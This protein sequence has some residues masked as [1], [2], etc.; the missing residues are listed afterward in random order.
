MGT[1]GA[2]REG[3]KSLGLSEQELA[4]RLGISIAA[5]GDLE[6]YDDELA[7][8]VSLGVNADLK[9]THLWAESPK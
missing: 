9:V 6:T 1:G 5:H 2:I 3:R 8:R 7:T 4:N